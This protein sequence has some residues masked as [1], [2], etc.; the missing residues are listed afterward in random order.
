MNPELTILGFLMSGPKSGYEIKNIANKMM[1]IYNLGFNQI[2]PVLKKLEK[3]GLV[4][5]EMVYQTG[6]PNKN[7]YTLSD[8]GKVIFFKKLTSSPQPINFEHDF[9]NRML[10]FRFLSKDQVLMQF[11]LEIK[12]IEKQINDLDSI[13]FEFEERSDEESKFACRT[14]LHLLKSMRNW[15]MSELG[16]RKF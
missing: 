5:K 11:E 16:R 9:L 3:E 4:H 7:V 2:Y 6:K 15:Y 14:T 1:M 12:A 10:F 13:R 8:T